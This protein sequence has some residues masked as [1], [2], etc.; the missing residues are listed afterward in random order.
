MNWLKSIE[1]NNYRTFDNETVNF[2][3]PNGN[4]GSG[5]NALIGPNSSGKSTVLSCLQYI[6]NEI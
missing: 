5:L 3:P 6:F 1:I 2:T 4:Y